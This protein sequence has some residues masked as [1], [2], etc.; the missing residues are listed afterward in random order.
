MDD[1]GIQDAMQ[2]VLPQNT[3]AGRQYM[4]ALH[5]AFIAAQKKADA[6]GQRED[7]IIREIVLDLKETHGAAY[8]TVYL[9]FLSPW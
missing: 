7:T 2:T 9:F 5:D 8:G 6:T 3:P 4:R 1:P